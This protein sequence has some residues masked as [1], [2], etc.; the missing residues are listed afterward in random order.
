VIREAWTDEESRREMTAEEDTG[1]QM[2]ESNGLQFRSEYGHL[3]R[4]N[5]L[6]EISEHL[7]TTSTEENDLETE[8]TTK[9]ASHLASHGEEDQPRLESETSTVFVCSE[10]GSVGVDILAANKNNE[11]QIVN[12][13]EVSVEYV[14]G[15]MF[16][17][18]MHSVP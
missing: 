4:S 3:S 12:A 5:E 10:S 16:R 1:L 18:V 11:Q 13:S 9:S 8:E 7:E 14:G 17:C 2:L 15:G 6:H